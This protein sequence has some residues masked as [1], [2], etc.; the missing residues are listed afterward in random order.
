MMALRQKRQLVIF[1]GT[2]VLLVIAAVAYLT[3]PPALRPDVVQ[4]W[5]ASLTP[6][7]G[8]T[9]VTQTFVPTSGALSA[10]GVRFAIYKPIKEGEVVWRLYRL[11]SD[12]K[13]TLLAVRRVP[14]S[15]IESG[16]IRDFAFTAIPDSL[17][18]TFQFTISAPE[19][20]KDAPLAVLLS[21]I[22]SFEKPYPL[23]RTLIAGKDTDQDLD[24]IAYSRR[25]NLDVLWTFLAGRGRFIQIGA[26]WWFGAIVA[27]L[28]V[29]AG[30][31]LA[32]FW[33]AG[34]FGDEE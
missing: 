16:A 25:S 33:E 3:R 4:N 19:L 5:S 32:R 1:T 31:M 28:A 9:V 13:K 6:V 11:D 23:N 17:G 27:G 12:T 15:T 34:A 21:G 14:A 29:A 8:K 2:V 7:Y 20:T 22:M 24:F 30:L 26:P 18:K 10:V